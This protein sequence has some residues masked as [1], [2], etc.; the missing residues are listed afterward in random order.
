MPR[1]ASIVIPSVYIGLVGATALNL[2]YCLI[3]YFWSAVPWTRFGIIPVACFLVVVAGTLAA[4]LV[5]RFAAE[6]CTASNHA[7][8]QLSIIVWLVIGGILSAFEANSEWIQERQALIYCFNVLFLLLALYVLWASAV[9]LGN[10]LRPESA[11]PSGG[12][13]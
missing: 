10:F 7:S 8:K 1:S 6:G 4:F 11:R 3:S 13:A 12:P 2:L 9:G 5:E